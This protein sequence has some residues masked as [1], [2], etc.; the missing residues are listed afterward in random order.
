[1][2][3]AMKI[4]NIV[5]PLALAIAAAAAPAFSAD[6]PT[7]P[8]KIIC[9]FGAGGVSDSA[10][11]IMAQAMEKALGQPV[12]V[13]NKPGAE[14]A[15][16][17]MTV[18]NS[19]A[20]GHTL[21]F[22]SSSILATPLVSKA[23]QYDGLRDFAAISTVGKFPYGMFVHPDVPA[24]TLKDFVAYARA[25]PGKINY[26]TVNPA[27]HL[28]ATNFSKAAQVEMMRVPYKTGPM[29]DL[30]AGRIQV[31]FG[32]VGN[33]IAHVKDGR[34]RMLAMMA[35][36]RSPLAPDVPTAEEAGIGA[37]WMPSYQMFLAP[38]STPPAVI[39]RLSKEVNA[40]LRDPKVRE[41]LEK[42]SMQVEGM[43]PQQL[44]ATL[45]GASR[46]WAEFFREAGIERQ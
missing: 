18:K 27:E 43:T 32:P 14:G 28:T 10:A 15:I 25:N 29:T 40:A 17:A 34:A 6:Y 44:R 2:E 4:K 30:I 12:V 35:R 46:T 42:T 45:E 23:A 26:G 41:Q 33:V 11:R 37:T 39:E 3:H 1:M 5:L 9:P 7:R 24:A 8:I 20:D 31:Y 21:L 38:A 13:E 36:E 22:A 16:A 19:P